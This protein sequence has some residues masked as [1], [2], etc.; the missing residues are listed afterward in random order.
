L[1]SGVI[2]NHWKFK[3][4]LESKSLCFTPASKFYDEL[5]GHYTKFDQYAWDQQLSVW[6]INQF[7][8]SI[9]LA[10]KLSVTQHNQK[11]IVISC[12]VLGV[13]ENAR[14]WRDYDGSVKSVA[15]ETTVGQLRAT[16]GSGFLM[17]RVNYI[18]STLDSIPKDHSLQPF[19]F[20]GESFEW[21]REVRIVCAMERGQRIGTLRIV[22][23][24]PGRLIRKIIISPFV[25]AAYAKEVRS[26][27]TSVP[28]SI[29][30]EESSLR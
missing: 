23:I 16:L 29:P 25:G 30:I 3:D 24:D 19:F 14:I 8:R 15:I 27:L 1:Y 4:L 7:V 17:V 2:L 5:E 10:S 28:L 20:K 13:E 21:E 18:D 9:A 22:P 11:A 6:G 12:W 26:L